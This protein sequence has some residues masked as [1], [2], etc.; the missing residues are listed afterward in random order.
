MGSSNI[1]QYLSSVKVSNVK[2][3]SLDG[4]T[5]IVSISATVYKVKCALG[6]NFKTQ[7]QVFLLLDTGTDPSSTSKSFF[8]S[9]WRSLIETIITVPLLWTVKKQL[10]G[11][12]EIMIFHIQIRN[13]EKISW[14]RILNELERLRIRLNFFHSLLCCPHFHAKNHAEEMSTCFH[15]CNRALERKP[16]VL[17]SC[18]QYMACYRFT[19]ELQDTRGA[20][21]DYIT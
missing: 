5:E 1:R 2:E 12:E 21:N 3:I 17:N 13:R 4:K 8:S 18:Q 19:V 20:T 16:N 14:F 7:I 6:I 11:H 10:Q 15:H 9:L